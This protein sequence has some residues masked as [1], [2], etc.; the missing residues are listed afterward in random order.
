VLAVLARCPGPERHN[1][2]SFE[3]RLRRQLARQDR[4]AV[5]TVTVGP[6]LPPPSRHAVVVVVQDADGLARRSLAWAQSLGPSEVRAVLVDL[7]RD[8]TDAVVGAWKQ[9][10]FPVELEVVPA[11]YRDPGGALWWR[12][13][14][15]RRA[16]YELVSVVIS[17]LAPRWWQRPLHESN[18]TRIRAA[19]ATE[20]ACAVV[21]APFP[22]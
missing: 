4:T 19:L 20:P 14:R 7:D 21:E 22:L 10:G 5:A 16:G 13:Q 2:L 8:T 18:A 15:L 11:P 9:R 6:A 12:V 3:R 1:P 17:E